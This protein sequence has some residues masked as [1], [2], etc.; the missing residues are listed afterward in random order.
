ML[1]EMWIAPVC[2]VVSAVMLAVHGPAS[3]FLGSSP[4]WLLWLISPAIAHFISRPRRQDSHA[5]S[6]AERRGLRLIARRTWLFFETFVTA[7]DHWLPP[8][9]F[10]E[11]PRG[12]IAH[13][14]SPTNEGMYLVSALAAHD[15]GFIGISTFV[16]C[17][18]RNLASWDSLEHFRGHP[19]NWYDTERHTT[20]MPAYIS[21]VDSG[22]LAAS[23]LTVR[24]GLVEL[25]RQAL[26]DCETIPG[27]GDT[28]ELLQESLEAAGWS[29]DSAS[30]EL[31]GVIR[32]GAEDGATNTNIVAR[33][34]TLAAI[35]T[36]ADRLHDAWASQRA[37]SKG[38]AGIP[39]PV[40]NRLEI[41]RKQIAAARDDLLA[42][43]P[44]LKQLG[45]QG[46]ESPPQWPSAGVQ[47]NGWKQTWQAISNALDAQLT[48]A[49]LADLPATTNSLFDQLRQSLAAAISE[50]ERRTDALHW[51][52]E[53]Q[54]AIAAGA[55][56]AAGMIARIRAL[57]TRLK[58]LADAMDFTFLYDSKRR[59]FAIGYN[60]TASQ[61]D[62]GR[63][64][65]LASEAR[66]AG[67][68]AIGKGDVD[69]RHW[70]HLG[71]P[72]TFTAGK[73]GLLSWGGTMFE[74][75]MPNLFLRSYP[76]TL[77]DEACQAAVDRQIEFG[78][79]RRVPWGI[80]ESAFST[81]DGGQNY[82]YQS[83]GV[84]GL[85]LKRGLAD[86]LVVA[87]YATGL[88]LAVRPHAAIVNFQALAA[89]GAAGPWGFYESLDYTPK[90]LASG[91]TRNVVRCYFA[92]HQGMLLTA[93]ANCL[94]NNRMRDRFHR[95]PATRTT[96][97]LLEERIP[98]TGSFVE[99]HGDEA[100]ETPVVR[101]ADR[102]FSRWLTTPQTYSP[103]THLIS[104]G[105]Y[106]AM[107]T[108]AGT[109]FSMCQATQITRWR[110]DTICDPWGQFIYLRDTSS[111]KLWSAGF[112]PVRQPADDYD[113]L[114]SVDKAE[115]TRRDGGIESHLEIA[116][117]PDHNVE[118][119]MLT[120]TNR[121]Q[122]AKVWT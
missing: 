16:E 94:L 107:V 114:F 24:Q 90:R 36:A 100:G 117:S 44:W 9:N 30:D 110:S 28:A 70:F 60:H 41:L 20:L 74:Y 83:F 52:N 73:T 85:G 96:E 101:E 66:L 80:S 108:N 69:F 58:L 79:Q 5:L 47:A 98:L 42:W 4:I 97:L 50:A 112:Q 40:S 91:Q 119:R 23:A 17:L 118:V 53:F 1:R 77:L 37:S 15:F 27:L 32:T 48:L 31:L 62:R 63:Y 55:A 33:H 89:A 87:P 95:E 34:Q 29:D 109:G 8:D 21:T 35:A 81:L 99:P 116:I 64:D 105:Q 19:Y 106:T 103:R 67:Y 25:E 93:V 46:F 122:R 115:I 3:L 76:E 84:P 22:N 10:Q 71:R 56:A 111:G 18:E 43:F 54:A 26:L 78:E 75:L 82:Q 14:T 104:N 88:A 113:V 61:L 49:V 7:E 59:L 11:E 51:I 12:V 102:P 45:P 120:L 121:G 39:Q 68:L 13:R 6:P 92:H 38:L 72:L 57:A 86:D 65:L 2:A